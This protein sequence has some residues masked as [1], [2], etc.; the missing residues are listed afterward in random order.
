VDVIVRF[1]A[2][3]PRKVFDVFPMLCMNRVPFRRTFPTVEVVAGR[4]KFPEVIVTLPVV[5]VNPVPPVMV[6]DAE[7]LVAREGTPPELVLRNALLAVDRPDTTLF[8]L[9]YKI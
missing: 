8:A 7:G 3:Y 5:A 6:P 4:A 1:P 9:L 2:L